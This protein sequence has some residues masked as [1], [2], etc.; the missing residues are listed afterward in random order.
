M[1]V[2]EIHLAEPGLQPYLKIVLQHIA[3]AFEK[4]ISESSQSKEQNQTIKIFNEKIR[5]LH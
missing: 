2:Q 5:V 3:N 1:K 4:A